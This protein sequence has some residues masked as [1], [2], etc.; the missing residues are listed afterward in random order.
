M[1]RNLSL[2]LRSLLFGLSSL[3]AVVFFFLVNPNAFV[4]EEEQP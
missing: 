4:V 2:A 3:V 1:L